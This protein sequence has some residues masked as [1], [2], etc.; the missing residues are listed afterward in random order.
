MAIND[1]DYYIKKT[2]EGDSNS[3]SVLVERYQNMVFALALKMLKHREESEEVSQ[4]TFI[5]VYKSLSKFNGESKFSTW[6]YRI[7]YNSCLDRI[8][9]NS[10]YNNN[11]EINEITSN[12]ISHTE[13]IFDSLE[14]KERSIIV[15]QCM[16]KLPEDERIIIHLFY[17]EELSLKEIVEI[18]SMTE[19]NVKVK[20]FRA[21]KK[22]FS[23]FK[24]SVE[25]EIY[26]SYER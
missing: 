21:R 2:L 10:K 1:D 15:K 9:K 26:S 5:K 11:V 22:L 19:G 25:P 14:N 8:K 4:D 12:E 24:E 3:F 6:I 13:S 23:I 7:A 20:L 18:V 17:F 16:D